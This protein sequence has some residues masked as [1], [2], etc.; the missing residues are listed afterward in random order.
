[1]MIQYYNF[2]LSTREALHLT[3]QRVKNSFDVGMG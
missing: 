2:T 3:L 1:M